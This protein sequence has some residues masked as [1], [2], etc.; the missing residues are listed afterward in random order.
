MRLLKKIGTLWRGTLYRSGAARRAAH[1]IH[2]SSIVSL[3]N[4]A[5]CHGSGM[6][7]SQSFERCKACGVTVHRHD[8][9]RKFVRRI[10]V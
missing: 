5:N 7:R 2:R 3:R 9:C 6:D 4:C 1:G 10:D 8:I